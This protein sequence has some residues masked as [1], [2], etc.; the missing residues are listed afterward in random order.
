MSVGGNSRVA[1]VRVKAW[2]L[3]VPFVLGCVGECG[4]QQERLLV[5]QALFSASDD[6]ERVRSS[7]EFDTLWAFGGPSDTLLATPGTPRLD[8]DGGLVFFDITN[9]AAYRIGADG[10]LLWSWGK[11]GEGPDEL[12]N[13]RAMDVEQDGSVV[14][15]DSGNRRVVRLSADGSPLETNRTPEQGRF[16]DDVA[17]LPGR[18]LAVNGG[19]P[20]S[21]LALWDGDGVVEPALP[22]EFGKPNPLHHQGGLV[23]WG[24]EGWVFGFRYG[25]GWMTFRGTELVGVFPY[26]EHS[27]FPKVREVRQGNRWH[28]QMTRRPAENG[29]SLSVVEDTL[30]VLFGG[31]SQLRGRLLDKFDVR[32]GAY[33]GTDVLPHY[34]NEAV[35]SW[36]RVFTVEAWDVFPSIVAL[37][38]RTGGASREA[39]GGR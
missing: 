25:N 22:T 2:M 4:G 28:M 8:G 34:A 18:R 29:L 16:V 15:V 32:S 20:G 37:A 31:E 10:H 11:K 36:D 26:V 23:R 35:V 27:D 1:G 21:V 5:A 39:E 3:A 33:L 14:L 12:L 24:D 38:R 17:A 6:V 9:Q 19:G 13:V 30:F 7:V